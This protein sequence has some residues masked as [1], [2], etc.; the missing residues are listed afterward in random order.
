MASSSRTRR[1]TCTFQQPCTEVVQHFVVPRS[2]YISLVYIS[3][4]LVLNPKLLERICSPPD[5]RSYSTPRDQS[6]NRRVILSI[7]QSV[8]G[9]IMHGSFS[10]NSGAHVLERTGSLVRVGMLLERAY[11]VPKFLLPVKGHGLRHLGPATCKGMVRLVWRHY[12][13]HN[14]SFN[15]N[16]C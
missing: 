1:G 12:R 4:C 15:Q 2:S 6:H 16:P 10:F 13:G 3:W 7:C 14:R 8:V 11:A 5:C 9:M